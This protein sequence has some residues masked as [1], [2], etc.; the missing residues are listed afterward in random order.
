MTRNRCNQPCLGMYL[1]HD[2]QFH[3]VETGLVEC[4]DSGCCEGEWACLLK[5]VC[6]WIGVGTFDAN[7]IVEGRT[8]EEGAV[9]MSCTTQVGI[10]E[11]VRYQQ[12]CQWCPI[13]IKY[14]FAIKDVCL[15]FFRAWSGGQATRRKQAV[16]TS[17]TWPSRL[18]ADQRHL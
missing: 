5:M 8:R 4:C 2:L 7:H 11:S 14:D 16:V 18:W 1:M 9:K 3:W 17:K 15:L 12:R 6:L 10:A 13:P